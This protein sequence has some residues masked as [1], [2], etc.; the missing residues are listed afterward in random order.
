MDIQELVGG[1]IIS[2][3][4]EGLLVQK[5][6][7]LYDVTLYETPEHILD[8]CGYNYWEVE[9]HIDLNDNVITKIEFDKYDEDDVDH[10][11]LNVFTNIPAFEVHGEAG[12]GSGW[13]YGQCVDVEISE[14]TL[15]DE[16]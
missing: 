6:D 15:H 4:T 1:K 5:G 11:T 2:H 12:S 14:V 7:K 10:I 3:G 8:C 9:D 13:D 16:D